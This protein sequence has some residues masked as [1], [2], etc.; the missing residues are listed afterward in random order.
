MQAACILVPASRMSTGRGIL[1]SYLGL[2]CLSVE[3]HE[4]AVFALNDYESELTPAGPAGPAKAGAKSK[5][6]GM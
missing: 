2:W 5:K 4:A 6:I 1:P 3:A